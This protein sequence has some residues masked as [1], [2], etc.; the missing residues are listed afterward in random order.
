MKNK[1]NLKTLSNHNLDLRKYTYSY[2]KDLTEKLDLLDSDFNQNI[3]DQIVLWKTNRY[4]SLDSKIFQLLNQI[5]RTDK[6]LDKE[7]TEEILEKLLD[8]E[9]KGI[10]LPMASTILRFKN[11][12][13]YQII[14]QRTYRI[15]YGCP[16]KWS[17][18]VSK[19][20]ETYFHY[21]DKLREISVEL[22][23]DFSE[24]DRILYWAD[25]EVN[26]DIPIKY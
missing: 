17:T 11:P 10:R 25:K 7:L 3:I 16:L 22:K 26:G 4:A 8:K 6:I 19:Q 13:I 14:D 5:K 18:I 1:K 21:L 20:I 9:T 15:I 2:Q 23:I 12:D 24:A